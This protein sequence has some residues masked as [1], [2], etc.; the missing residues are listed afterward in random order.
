MPVRRCSML[1][2]WVGEVRRFDCGFV[3]SEMVFVWLILGREFFLVDLHGFGFFF[4]VDNEEL[5]IRS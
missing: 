2:F 1:V 5:L 3:E 4:L